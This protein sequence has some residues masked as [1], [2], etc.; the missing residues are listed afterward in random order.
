L[1][2]GSAKEQKARDNMRQIRH[3]VQRKKRHI[4]SAYRDHLFTDHMDEIQ[5]PN[6]FAEWANGM[7]SAV[8]YLHQVMGG[9]EDDSLPK[10]DPLWFASIFLA[11]TKPTWI[12]KIKSGPAEEVFVLG[13]R[14]VSNAAEGLNSDVK[15]SL[16][17]GLL[18]YGMCQIY[19]EAI[20]LS[21]YL[22]P[23]RRAG[24]NG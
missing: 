13:Q 18:L 2:V 11:F 17:H 12:E 14:H 22:L 20:A 19:G 1:G 5:M 8:L 15:I 7:T 21:L 9:P 23:H 3:G 24:G 16:A 6:R 10:F 4:P